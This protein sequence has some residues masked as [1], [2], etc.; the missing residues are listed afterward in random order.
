MTQVILRRRTHTNTYGAVCELRAEQNCLVHRI[1][2]LEAV[3]LKLQEQ[4]RVLP[5]IVRAA[6]SQQQ[7]S[8]AKHT[9]SRN[10][11]TSLINDTGT[12]EVEVN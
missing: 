8:C 12:P 9:N 3:I 11:E 4:L 2:M 7:Y 1:E 5:G 6:I 10:I